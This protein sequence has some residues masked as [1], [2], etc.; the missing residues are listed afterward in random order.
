MSVATRSTATARIIASYFGVGQL[1]GPQGTWGSIAALPVGLLWLH[2]SPFAL[3]GVTVLIAG[4]GLWAVKEL[5]AGDDPGWVVI[6]EVVGQWIAL[7]PLALLAELTLHYWAGVVL[8]FALFRLFDIWKPGPIGRI[9]RL[10]GPWGVM[11]DDVFAG[12]FAA[13]I[14]LLPVLIVTGHA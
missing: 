5:D 3:L 1:A 2:I 10:G 9:D 12:I 14:L 4:A 7:L 8:A 6:D 11:M 13:A